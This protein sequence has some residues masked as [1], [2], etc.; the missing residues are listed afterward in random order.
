MAE[1]LTPQSLIVELA[2]RGERPAVVTVIGDEARTSSGAE[3]AEQAE[4]LA[5]G[6][7]AAG[8]A[9]GE[10]VGLYGANRPEW[11][12]VRLALGAAGALVAPFDDLLPEAEVAP[13][14]AHC[15][16][17][18][19]FTTREHLEGL[20]GLL[21]DD[22]PEWFLLDSEPDGSASGSSDDGAPSW[23]SL[24]ATASGPLPA[25]DPA[26]PAMVVTT[27][28]TTGTPKSFTLSHANL[29]ANVTA[30]C[31]LGVVGEGDRALLPLPMD[32]VYPTVVGLLCILHSGAT[33]VFPEALTGPQI[34][35]A[36]KV[37]E[38]SLL[39]GVPRLYA[40]VLGGIEGRVAARSRVAQALFTRLLSLSIALR[41]RWGLRAGRRI[42]GGLHRQVGPELRLLISGGAKLEPI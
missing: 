36:L 38:A 40:A 2:A 4:R 23:Q 9:P 35:K 14:I 39:I 28:G 34:V 17:R 19:V 37:G 1:V 5:S 3:L 26:A 27:S 7:L 22:E 29:S 30:I 33:L 25:L 12:V 41:R 24:M 16:C 20:R 8:V 6:L 42:F 21:G 13:L 15:R 11:I 18:R 32:N 10:P 31:A